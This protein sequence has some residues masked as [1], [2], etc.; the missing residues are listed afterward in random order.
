MFPRKSRVC[1][2]TC[3]RKVTSLPL[4]YVNPLPIVFL[5]VFADEVDQILLA[6]AP[7]FSSES[8]AEE[9]GCAATRQNQNNEEKK[10]EQWRSNGPANGVGL[11]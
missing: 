11:K 9:W 6:T 2:K 8:E 7:N 3:H 5:G 10:T 1:A 4:K